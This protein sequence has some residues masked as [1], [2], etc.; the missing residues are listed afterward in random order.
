MISQTAD[1]QHKLAAHYVRSG[2]VIAY[3]TESVWGLGCDPFNEAAIEHVLALKLRPMAK[4]MILLSGQAEHF[5]F[6]VDSMTEEQR[7]RLTQK[8]DRPTTWLVP[9]AARLVSPWIKGEHD[10]VAIRVS[11]SASVAK[12]TKALGHPIISTSANPAS[13]PT[14]K[15]ILAL[16]QYFGQRLDYIL[17]GA[18]DP[19]AQSSRIINIET[20]EIVRA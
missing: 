2:G 4:G 8:S 7:A 15:N 9:D 12:L 6:L 10:F 17:P 11:T 13:R 1:F 3:A 5:G 16:R 20:G 18:V 14:A 19:N